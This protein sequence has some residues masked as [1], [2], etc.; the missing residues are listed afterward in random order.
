MSDYDEYDDEYVSDFEGSF[1]DDEEKI[2][3]DSKDFVFDD[4]FGSNYDNS[5][6]EEDKE[7]LDET[8]GSDYDEEYEESLI[9]EVVEFRPEVDVFERV[10][11]PDQYLVPDIKNIRKSTPK[12]RF[13]NFVNSIANSIKEEF[14]DFI[15][16]D[17][18]II[19]LKQ[20]EKIPFIEFKNPLGF[21]VGYLVINSRRDID[22]FKYKKIT[23]PN[24]LKKLNE[25]LPTA[26]LTEPDIIRYA[27]L[28]KTI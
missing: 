6:D 17:E 8:F 4:D 24:N 20:S 18:I 9:R 13:I 19:I 21:I 12:E 15:T 23:K 11:L 1:S 2:D 22:D 7:D 26:N 16:E 27:R 28:W 14:K 3:F 10:G 25:L 5:G